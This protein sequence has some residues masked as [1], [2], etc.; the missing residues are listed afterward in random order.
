MALNPSKDVACPYCG[1]DSVK[2]TGYELFYFTED[3]AY[4]SAT[5]NC[6]SCGEHGEMLM[7][8]SI[9]IVTVNDYNGDILVE[10]FDD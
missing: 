8:L 2:A 4:A 10:V 1:C 3:G 5:W 7:S 9:D 6:P